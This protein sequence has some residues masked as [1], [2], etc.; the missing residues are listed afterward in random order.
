MDAEKKKRLASGIAQRRADSFA[1]LKKS[2]SF[3]AIVEKHSARREQPRKLAR[4]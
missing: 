1:K 4:S 2:P 3:K